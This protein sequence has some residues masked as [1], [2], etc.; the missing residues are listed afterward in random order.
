MFTLTA[1]DRHGII[2][3]GSLTD[4]NSQGERVYTTDLAVTLNANGGGL[5]AKTGLYLIN[6]DISYCITANESKGT[7]LEDF[8]KK[9]RRQLVTDKTFRIRRLTPLECY[10]LM[11]FKDEDFRRIKIAG[12]SDT[13]AY[14]QA[15]NS[16][17][18]DVLEAVFEKLFLNI[19][20]EHDYK[21]F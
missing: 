17:V 5:G 14:R 8:L 13:Q 18:V 4:R 6:G 7:T 10:R 19:I 2:K 9:K 20:E 15:G 3:I 11:G 1:Q 16:I 21:L 12:I